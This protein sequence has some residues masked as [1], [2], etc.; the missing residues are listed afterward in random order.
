MRMLAAFR[1]RSYRFQWPADLLTSWAF[2]METLI[3]GWYVLVATESVLMLTVFGSLQFLGTLLS[4]LFGVAGDRLGR[5]TTLAAM[6]TAYTLLAAVLMGLGLSGL[7]TPYAAFAVAFFS[8]LIRPSD[9]VLRYALIG[10]TIPGSHLTGAMGLARAT[11]DSAKIAGALA[12]AG[13]FAVLGLGIAYI[14]VTAFYA[15]GLLL[16]LGVSRDLPEESDAGPEEA[17]RPPAARPSPRPSQWRELRDGLAY[18]RNAPTVLALMWLAF[19]VNLTA[20]PFTMG[21]LPYVAKDIYGV[22]ETGLGYMVAVLAGGALIGSLGATV[23]GARRYSTRGMILNILVWY[24]LLAGFALVETMA[25]GLV[26]LGL[27]GMVQS[28]AMISMSTALLRESSARFRAR[29]MGV[30]MLAVYGL[31]MGL[32]AMGQGIEAVGY[33]TTVWVCVLIGAGLTVL[34]ARRWRAAIWL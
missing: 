31:P 32:L 20:Y 3:L 13:L 29:V 25:A 6:R 17:A 33:R 15:A 14:A 5:R 34:V 21:L 9:L 10:D 18:V 30:R 11:Q 19:L 26:I 27:M 7:I 28:L 4:P 8:G 2:E 22:D 24:A 23:T 12:G 16:T 1:V